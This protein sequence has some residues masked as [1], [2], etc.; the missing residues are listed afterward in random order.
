MQIAATAVPIITPLNPP[1]ASAMIAA[2]P[3]SKK[4]VITKGTTI[5]PKKLIEFR[6]NI[7]GTDTTI[8][9]IKPIISV[10]GLYGNNNGAS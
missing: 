2:A 6:K 10:F 8:A 9:V 4:Q 5:M 1:C 7:N 3:H